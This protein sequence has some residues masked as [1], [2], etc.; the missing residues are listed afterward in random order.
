MKGITNV[1]YV[2]NPLRIPNNL[3]SSAL[4]SHRH[5]QLILL[6]SQLNADHGSSEPQL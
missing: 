1:R 3:K 5:G 6:G 2:I 4:A